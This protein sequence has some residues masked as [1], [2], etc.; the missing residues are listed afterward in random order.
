M[1][2]EGLHW[3]VRGTGLAMGAVLVL[4]LVAG[5][6]LAAKVV[7]LVAIAILLAAGLEP[8]VAWIRNRTPLG[9]SASILVA[10][11]G[12]FVIVLILLVLIV[13]SAATQFNEFGRRLP[14]LLHDVRSWAATVR[15]PAVGDSVIA[16]AD[17]LQRTLV[18]S[19]TAAPDAEDLLEVGITL[20][21]LVI[22][23]ITILTLIFFWLTGHHRLQRFFLALLPQ[24]RRGGAREAWNEIESRLG[25][26]V[27]GQLILMGTMFAMTT[28]A[29]FLLGLE[30]ALVLGVI[31][32]VAEAIPLIG[33][34]LGAVPA[35][36]VAALTGRLE[37]VAL[38]AVVYVVIQIVEGNVLVPLVMK[39]TV[40]VPPFLV[41]VS[42]IG[43]VAIGGI[44]GALLAVPLTAV[45]VMLLERLQ[46]RESPVPLESG[47]SL[48]VPT[49]D[50]AAALGRTLPDARGSFTGGSPD[51]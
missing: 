24:Q 5:V 20:A 47:G 3:F 36:L 45:V 26:W 44:I 40:G 9:R 34:A 15:P 51:R 48:H 7:V 18:P 11:V 17:L 6:V 2:A 42:I 30:G 8:V 32:G 16:I 37:L 22:S 13:P 14:G 38:V 49:E 50:E 28:V 4:G 29:Y 39:N 27:R 43:G 46:A 21:D 25:L 31:A 12:F 10:F 33:P 1:R 35:L 23:V 41:V 19:S